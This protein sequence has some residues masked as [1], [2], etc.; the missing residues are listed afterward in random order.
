MNE[1]EENFVD[2]NPDSVGLNDEKLGMLKRSLEQT[3]D[4]VVI[5]GMHAPP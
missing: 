3:P 4:G 1:S 5:V 2:S